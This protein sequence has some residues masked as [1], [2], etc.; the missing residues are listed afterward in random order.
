MEASNAQTVADHYVE[1]WNEPDGARR[2]AAIEC[3]WAPNGAHYVGARAAHGYEALVQRVSG[4]HE[5]N[6]RD[7]GYRFRAVKDA[8]G[9]RDAV[10]FHWEMVEPATGRVAATGLEMLLLDA[11]QKIRIDY[12]FIVS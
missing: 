3:L 5:K 1:L 7:G 12:Q 6:V 11:D 9:L 10:T 2:R 4:S 8:K